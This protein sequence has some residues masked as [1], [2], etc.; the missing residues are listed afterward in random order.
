MLVQGRFA[1]PV[2]PG[3]ALAPRGSGLFL[4]HAAGRRCRCHRAGMVSP[5]SGRGSSRRARAC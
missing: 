4:C 2:L 3:A 5:L 1:V